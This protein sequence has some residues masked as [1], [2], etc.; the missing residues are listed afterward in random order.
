MNFPKG[1]GTKNDSKGNKRLTNKIKINKIHKLIRVQ[2]DF[3]H[4]CL[5][6]QVKDDWIQGSSK[7]TGYLGSLRRAA[8][9]ILLPSDKFKN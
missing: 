3:Q 5:D 8:M 7:E 2:I 9:G 1:I 6:F 4:Q